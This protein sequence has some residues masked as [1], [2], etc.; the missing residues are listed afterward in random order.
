MKKYLVKPTRIID[1]K[2]YV[3]TIDD[4]LEN[5]PT[6]G[7]GS[8]SGNCLLNNVTIKPYE[9]ISNGAETAIGT[10]DRNEELTQT[11]NQMFDTIG[12]T[13]YAAAVEIQFVID[14]KIKALESDKTVNDNL[15][16][17]LSS[18]IDMVKKT[19]VNA[20]TQAVEAK[21]ETDSL[22]QNYESLK[23]RVETLENLDGSETIKVGPQLMGSEA[24]NTH[25]VTWHD[26]NGAEETRS[27][28][29]GSTA[30]LDQVIDW[31]HE[32]LALSINAHEARI[33][34]LTTT[35][36]STNS[37]FLTLTKQL[38]T[39]NSKINYNAEAISAN[40]SNISTLTTN[41]DTLTTNVNT[42]TDNYTTLSND[43]DA[44]L[45]ALESNSGTA[46]G[47]C[48]E[49][50][51]LLTPYH[52][53]SNELLDKI[54]E[55]QSEVT[56]TNTMTAT[57]VARNAVIYAYECAGTVILDN[58]LIIKPK[59]TEL[60]NQVSDHS[61]SIATLR[62]DVDAIQI[63]ADAVTD[64]SDKK[65]TFTKSIFDEASGSTGTI[66]KNDEIKDVLTEMSADIA[67]AKNI[68]NR[69]VSYYTSGGSRQSDTLANHLNNLNTKTSSNATSITSLE[70]RMTDVETQLTGVKVTCTCDVEATN[71]RFTA[72][73][74][75]FNNL[76]EAMLDD[77]D[78]I[79]TQL[80]AIHTDLPDIK[81]DP[82]GNG[83]TTMYWNVADVT[84]Q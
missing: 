61:D 75:A 72:L 73:T 39:T 43:V 50:E 67:S 55:L 34:D 84:I 64:I 69:T 76:K 6:G 22:F 53:A 58:D 71:N 25:V 9:I 30:S 45:T 36:D 59:I 35:V 60:Q 14:P 49:E 65:V 12:K 79:W 46:S 77:L 47:D 28:T 57:V 40:T 80:R 54:N 42:L 4:Y 1:E 82:S 62:S 51:L 56:V 2:G 17:D 78:Y 26:T 11:A 10:V 66:D 15:L 33:T 24:M 37:K 48:L 29:Y 16:N 38:G 63:Q 27:L 83:D 41:V 68:S 20:E 23:T 3:Q 31:I 19:A 32:P 52:Q 13:A 5:V 8:G 7:S 21:S 18:E 74:N 70:N 81:R 44:R